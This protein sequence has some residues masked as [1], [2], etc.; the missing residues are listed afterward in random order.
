MDKINK[1]GGE[2]TKSILLVML[3]ISLLFNFCN[4]SKG[5]LSITMSIR[6][7]PALETTKELKPL[8]PKRLQYLTQDSSKNHPPP[9]IATTPSK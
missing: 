8:K 4:S 2:I 7:K 9:L 5:H 6:D 1:G 3:L